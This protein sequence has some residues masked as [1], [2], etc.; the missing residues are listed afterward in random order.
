MNN[1]LRCEYMY[2]MIMFMT[3][4]ELMYDYVRYK[5]KISKECDADDV[6]RFSLIVRLRIVS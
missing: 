1:E 6:L 5:Y 3:T 4:Y 2:D